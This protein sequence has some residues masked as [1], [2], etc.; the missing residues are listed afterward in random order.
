MKFA[1]Y[2]KFMYKTIIN[3]FSNARNFS[4]SVMVHT[5]SY[6]VSSNITGIVMQVHNAFTI[7]TYSI[8][9]THALGSIIFIG[10]RNVCVLEGTGCMC[11]IQ[12]K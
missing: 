1:V 9:L 5:S 3:Q 4:R 6:D 11:T 8:V 12:G 2:T 7:I 10:L